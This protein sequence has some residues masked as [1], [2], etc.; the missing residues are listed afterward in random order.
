MTLRTHEEIFGFTN[1]TILFLEAKNWPNYKLFVA[2]NPPI[3]FLK[4]PRSVRL[5]KIV[6]NVTSLGRS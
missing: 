2:K 5:R 6:V 3:F 4:Q 1:T